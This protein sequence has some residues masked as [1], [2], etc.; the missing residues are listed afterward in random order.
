MT[1]EENDVGTELL[2]DGKADSFFLK[3]FDVLITK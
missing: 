1:G 2:N 3:P